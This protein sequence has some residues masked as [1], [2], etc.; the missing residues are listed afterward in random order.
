MTRKQLSNY[1]LSSTHLHKYKSYFQLIVMPAGDLNLNWGPVIMIDNK[2]GIT[3]LFVIV[4][5]L[6]AGL[7]TTFDSDITNSGI[8]WRMFKNNGMHFIHLSVNSISKKEEI[9]HLAELTNA[10]VIDISLT[11]VDGSVLNSEMVTESC[12]I[13]LQKGLVLLLSLNTFLL[14]VIKP[15]CVL[16][17]KVFF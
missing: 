1:A 6:L 12:C 9:D 2:C 14:T 10:S 13:V 8:K 17:R 7:K 11:K 16:T 3:F 15:K 5:F 4:I